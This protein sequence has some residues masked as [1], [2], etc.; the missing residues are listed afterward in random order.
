MV[1]TAAPSAASSAASVGAR[2]TAISAA[3]AQLASANSPIAATV[4]SATVSGSPMNKS[5]LGNQAS[6]STSANRNDEREMGHV[7]TRSG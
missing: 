6:R 2:I 1:T 7:N 4:P 3:A 5:R